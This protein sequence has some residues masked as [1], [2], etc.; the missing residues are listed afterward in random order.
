LLPRILALEGL[1]AKNEKVAC[2]LNAAL[3]HGCIEIP[4]N[5]RIPKTARADVELK[6]SKKIKT[7]SH[8]HIRFC[9]EGEVHGTL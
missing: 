4:A 7:V 1:N 2:A 8:L 3:T 6:P 5:A 9:S